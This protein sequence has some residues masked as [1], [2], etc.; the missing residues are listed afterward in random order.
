MDRHHVYELFAA[1]CR[2]I[3]RET[4]DSSVR[5]GRSAYEAMGIHPFEAERL[6]RQFVSD[7]L[8]AIRDLAQHY[9]PDIPMHKNQEYV[10]KSREY[11][12]AREA[13]MT[14]GGRGF[15]DR[16]DRGWRPPTTGDVETEKDANDET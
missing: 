4:F 9:N 6:S 12:E 3:I 16:A 7:D 10:R 5:V 14:T 13:E 1:G 11:R 2:D 8:R 15:S